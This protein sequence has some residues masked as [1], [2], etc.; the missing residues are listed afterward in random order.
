MSVKA[1]T[2]AIAVTRTIISSL[3]MARTPSKPR[4]KATAERKILY[5]KS[6]D[7]INIQITRKAGIP[8]AASRIMSKS[9][10]TDRKQQ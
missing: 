4:T 9:A 3:E 10:T 8:T 1:R 7:A 6:K 5:R 2:P